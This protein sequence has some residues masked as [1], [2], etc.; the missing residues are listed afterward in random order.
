MKIFTKQLSYIILATIFLFS[1]LIFFKVDSSIKL[2][3]TIESKGQSKIIKSE[4]GGKVDYFSLSVFQ[5]FKQGDLI[6]KIDDQMIFEQINNLESQVQVLDK[7]KKILSL[8]L[9]IIDDFNF[10]KKSILNLELNNFDY[11][12]LSDYAENWNSKKMSVDSKIDTNIKLISEIESQILIQ[13]N[14]VNNLSSIFKKSENLYDE[15]IISIEQL[16]K[17]R[18][19]YILEI[20]NLSDYKSSLIKLKQQIDNLNSKYNNDRLSEKIKL[21]E[22]INSIEKKVLE[23]RQKLI[24]S[25]EEFRK[26]NIYSP[27]DGVINKATPITRGYVVQKGEVLGEI[28]SNDNNIVIYGYLPSNQI[29]LIKENDLAKV[30]TIG[31]KSSSPKKYIARV[32]YISPDIYENSNSS[33]TNNEDFYLLELHSDEMSVEDFNIG[34]PVEIFIT[35]FEQSVFEYILG[36]I[37]SFYENTFIE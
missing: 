8:K 31:M 24:I 14:N 10:L 30:K 36:P 13:T 7:Q 4:I 15:K 33:F 3:G 9:L 22:N 6:I 25:E 27:I 26:Y 21:R 2:I 29:E 11:E 32:I 1:S 5:K 34:Q 20:A 28:I 12:L 17:D 16:E 35:L 19:K 37:I 18:Q 23:I